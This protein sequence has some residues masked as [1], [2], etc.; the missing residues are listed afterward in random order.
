MTL[1][2]IEA[3]AIDRL[4]ASPL[5]T[6]RP[7]QGKDRQV[8]AVDQDE[9]RRDRKPARRAAH[10]GQRRAPDVQGVDLRRRAPASPT[11]RARAPEFPR[12]AS[13][14]AAAESFLESSRPSREIVG[15]ENDRR[16]ADRPGERTAPDLVD[17]RHRPEPLPDQFGLKLEMRRHQR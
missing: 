12:K 8:A 11:P 7:G 17:S 5:M 10:A 6:A 16:D 2:T 13:R 9:T 3:A 1:A 15:V 14:A 4:I